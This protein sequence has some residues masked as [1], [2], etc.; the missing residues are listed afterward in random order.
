MDR[1]DQREIVGGLILVAF[2]LGMAIY[3]SM[4]YDL[5]TLRRMGPGM[6]PMGLGY[7]LAF[8]GAASLLPTLLGKGEPVRFQPAIKWGPA[9]TILLSVAAF[10]LLIRPFGLIPAILATTLIAS[11]AEHG[12][13][14]WSILGLCAFLVALSYFLFIYALGLPMRTVNWPL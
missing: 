11:Q 10:A 6:F 3:S 13:R 5:G 14:P 7:L 2:G 1:R 4:N 9:G 8:L 12:N